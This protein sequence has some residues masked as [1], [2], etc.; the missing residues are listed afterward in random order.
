MQTGTTLKK[1]GTRE[2]KVMT[3]VK[4]QTTDGKQL[5]D[6]IRSKQQ[7]G[8]KYNPGPVSKVIY[9]NNDLWRYAYNSPSDIIVSENV[10]ENVIIQYYTSDDS[11]K[12]VDVNDGK[13]YNKEAEKFIDKDLVAEAERQ[14][15]EKK[16]KELEELERKQKEENSM[17]IVNFTD[18]YLQ[19]LEKNIKLTNDEKGIV[20]KLNDCN[21]QIIKVL[22]E[23]LSYNGSIEQYGLEEKLNDIIREE[24]KLVEEGLKNIIEEDRTG[25][26]ILKIFEA[27][28]SSEMG[29]RDF[30]M[31]QQKKAILFAD[32][33]VNK[34]VADIEQA[35][36]IVERGKVE[37]GIESINEILSTSRNREEELIKVKVTLVYNKAML[38]NYY[39][40]RSTLKD[41]YFKNEET[42]QKLSR[43]VVVMVTNT[44]PN[45][46]IRLFNKVNSL[47]FSQQNEL[48]AIM[49]L[50]NSQQL[51]TVNTAITKISDG[52]TRKF[53]IKLF[54]ELTGNK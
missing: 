37:K 50:L 4:V 44:L 20:N 2:K 38:D 11:H 23:A 1:K 34:N 18:Q 52:K 16:Q 12:K 21:T 32:Y 17:E 36:Y 7:V 24:K 22:H 28:T 49:R 8:S 51:G 53:A 25:T 3:I 30:N 43:E 47:N 14:E 35:I 33:F 15:L 46:A 29:D 27:I 19:R 6:D 9:D 26:K 13:Y 10:E 40:A 41:D 54:K 5:K 31:L 42:K 48:D 45:Q 39:R